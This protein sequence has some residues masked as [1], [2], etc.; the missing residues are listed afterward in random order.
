[1]LR[2]AASKLMWGER[3]TVLMVGIA[4]LAAL[5]MVGLLAPQ[6]RAVST[7]T[8]N[9]T[10]DPGTGGC[11]ATECTLREAIDAANAN[12]NPTEKDL[13]KFN[14]PGPGVHTI[15]PAEVLPFI[16]EPVIIDGYSQPN[17]LANSLAKGTNATLLIE[18]DG[19]S[20]D[21]DGLTIQAKNCVVKGLVIN[22][23][24]SGI[25]VKEGSSATKIE[26]NFIGTDPSG[27]VAKGNEFQGVNLFFHSKNTTVGGTLPAKR[28][29]ISG[30]DRRGVNIF[31]STGNK[32][33][34]NLIGTQKDGITALGN[35]E[36]GI[37]AFNSSNNFVGNG[38]SAG[39]NTI[40][41]NGTVSEDA[42]VEIGTA[43]DEPN[44]SNGN[45]I[46]RNSIFSNEGLGIDLGRDGRTLNDP[47][48]ADVGANRLQNFPVISSAKTVSGTTTIK[49]TLDSIPVDDLRYTIEFFSNPSSG[50]EGKTFIGKK[51]VSTNGSGHASFTFSPAK[52]VSVGETITATA[53]RNSTG[54]TSEFSLPRT[55]SSS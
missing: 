20:A 23:F 53:T 42:G 49:G 48:D 24:A 35:G 15:S 33:L 10:A 50:D 25:I 8:V 41:F 29:L 2:N 39:S 43:M 12:N 16:T 27:T 7:F 3:T 14:I 6:A 9:S 37:D 36:S 4:L 19:S 18:L 26:G 52:A 38:S 13:I 17:S 47:G 30:N 1:M 44:K 51:I 34:G 21:D 32:V 31:V 22:N 55:V 28:N 46:L 5:V 54:D 40:A 45:R 11:D